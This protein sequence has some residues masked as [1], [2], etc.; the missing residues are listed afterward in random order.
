MRVTGTKYHSQR[1]ELSSWA[2]SKVRLGYETRRTG[3]RGCVVYRR[4]CVFWLSGAYRCCCVFLG[5]WLSSLDLGVP[6]LKKSARL[7]D[8]SNPLITLL[9]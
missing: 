8:L 9:R 5:E 2:L 7:D 3:V 1:R 4:C 6:D